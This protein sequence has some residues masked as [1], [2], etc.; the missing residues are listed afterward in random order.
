MIRNDL[1]APPSASTHIASTEETDSAQTTHSP[2]KLT[3]DTTGFERVKSNGATLQ[4][5]GRA[6][7][8]LDPLPIGDARY[9]AQKLA[10]NTNGFA[11]ITSAN[12][13]TTLLS[14]HEA[15]GLPTRT[16][17]PGFG[18]APVVWS[19]QFGQDGP[20]RDM[21]ESLRGVM[22]SDMGK[23]LNKRIAE[24]MKVPVREPERDGDFARRSYIV[25]TMSKVL[26][27]KGF[28]AGEAS[29]NAK[30]FADLAGINF[31]VTLGQAM[32]ESTLLALNP[33]TF[34][35]AGLPYLRLLD[36]R[37]TL[38]H[39]T[40]HSEGAIKKLLSGRPVDA[41]FYSFNLDPADPEDH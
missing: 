41:F 20:L 33:L 18:D 23:T 31:A 9:A 5:I 4:D 37:Q 16:S 35:A 30:V 15:Q 25:Y 22:S 32:V 27:P 29:H 6:L 39:Q 40:P 2:P 38:P 34:L 10:Q 19:F 12:V 7:A 1:L 36:P 21:A 17:V 8:A 28:A 13:I 14:I 26:D 3:T 24:A 11:N